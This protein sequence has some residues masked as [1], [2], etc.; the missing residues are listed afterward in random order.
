MMA[1]LSDFHQQ[2]VK[3]GSRAW[4]ADCRSDQRRESWQT[5]ANLPDCTGRTSSSFLAVKFWEESGS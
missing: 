2:T 4:M 3:L 5:L 1:F